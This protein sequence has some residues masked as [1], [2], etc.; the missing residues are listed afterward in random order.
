[1]KTDDNLSVIKQIPLERL[2]IETDSPLCD[3]KT[4]SAAYKYIKTF[5]PS[6]RQEKWNGTTLIRHRNEPCN[7]V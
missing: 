1:M 7:V 5:Y 6:V 3:I 2:L 4:S